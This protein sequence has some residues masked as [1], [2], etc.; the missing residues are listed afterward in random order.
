MLSQATR[1]IT[2][3]VVSV[4][5]Q[6]GG[7]L[8]NNDPVMSDSQQSVVCFSDV[9]SDIHEPAVLVG[10]KVPTKTCISVSVSILLRNGTIADATDI[11]TMSTN[12]VRHGVFT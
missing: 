10:T 4:L 2:C 3:Y 11:A 9:F 8:R 12:G 1:A 6:S 7:S 5:Q